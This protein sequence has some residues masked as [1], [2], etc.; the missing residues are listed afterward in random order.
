[1]LRTSLCAISF[2]LDIKPNLATDPSVSN[3]INAKFFKG[4]T[5]F[6]S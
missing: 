4:L 3:K 1:M 5:K 6:G 2:F